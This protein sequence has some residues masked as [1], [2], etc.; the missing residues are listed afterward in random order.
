[1]FSKKEL[2]LHQVLEAAHRRHALKQRFHRLGD[3]LDDHLILILSLSIGF[4]VA[5]RMIHV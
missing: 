2:T 5:W 4:V 3:W 1:M